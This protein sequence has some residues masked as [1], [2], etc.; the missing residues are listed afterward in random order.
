MLTWKELRTL[1]KPS[2][3]ASP[4]D[5]LELEVPL[6]VIAPLFFAAQK[7]HH[8]ARKATNVSA[9][10]PNLFFGFP[11]AAPAAPLPAESPRLA[12]KP[13]APLPKAPPTPPLPTSP[14]SSPTS[15]LSQP[16][17]KPAGRKN[18]ETNFFVW[19]EQGETP[20]LE[21]VDYA[22][23]KVPQTDFT[24]RR[25]MPRD[26]VAQAVKLPGVAGAVVTLPDGLRVASEV[27]PGLNPD[28]LSAF[29]PQIYERMNQSTREL[30]MGV[31]N[32]IAFT[33]GN[34]PWKIFRVNSVYFAVFGRAG[35][36]LPAAQLAELAAELD[37]KKQ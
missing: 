11:Q 5:A 4:N 25:A 7:G 6:K 27:I 8:P 33:V 10:I 2:S 36:S 17:P 15:Q 13:A 30:R 16:P 23:P 37:R 32:N 35:S 18:G 19:G 14:A 28:T 20:R 21:E 31:L 24:N 9:E 26:V 22:P 1:A 12:P 3:P 34:I 29:I